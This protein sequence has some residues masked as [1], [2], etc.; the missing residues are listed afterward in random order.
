MCVPAVR[1]G[2]DAHTVVFLKLLLAVFRADH[3]YLITA[4]YDGSG[5]VGKG[6]EEEIFGIVQKR[7]RRQSKCQELHPG[8]AAVLPL[9]LVGKWYCRMT[10]AVVVFSCKRD[11][12]TKKI[13]PE[14]EGHKT[15]T[16]SLW[17]GTLFPEQCPVCESNN[18]SHGAS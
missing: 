1:I 2:I 9:S 4:K 17:N 10:Q 14:C 12:T 18:H 13:C 7:N 15:N 3:L 11:H 16:V 8:S 5:W 6:T